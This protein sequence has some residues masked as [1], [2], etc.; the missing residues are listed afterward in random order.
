MRE[1]CACQR[2]PFKNREQSKRGH[3]PDPPI[4]RGGV[5]LAMRQFNLGKTFLYQLLAEGKVR[6]MLLKREGRV[7]GKRMIDLGSLRAFLESRAEKP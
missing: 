1:G 2:Q 3:L 5:S 4:E 7:R 6:T